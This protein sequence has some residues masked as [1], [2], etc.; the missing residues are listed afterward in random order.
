MRRRLVLVFFAISTLVA[1]AFVIPLGVL[2]G[3]T[4][5][6]RAID[7][8]RADA[9]AVV[10]A[11]TAS[12]SRAQ[13]ESAMGATAAGSDGRMSVITSQGWVIGAEASQSTLIETALEF[14]SS[15]IGPVDGGVEVVAAVAS[16][17]SE[18]SAI[19]VFVPQESLESGRWRAWSVLAAVGLA[20]VGI[21]V[22]VADRLARTVTV[23]MTQLVNAA[24]SL[25]EGDL[26]V[27]VSPDGP[28]ELADLAGAFNDLGTRVSTMLDRER[29]LVADLSHRMRTPL[30]KLRL[31]VDQVDDPTLAQELRSDLDD[32]TKEVNELIL[33]ARGAIASRPGCDLNDVAT[34]RAEFWRVL[35]DDQERPWIFKAAGRPLF[36]EPPVGDVAAA[37]DVLI[38]NVFSHTPEGAALS[39]SCGRRDDVAE[40]VVGDGGAGFASEAA[41]RGASS[42]GSTGLGLDIARQTAM[43]FGGSLDIGV[44][45]LGG[46]SV[47]LRLPVIAPRT[48]N[49]DH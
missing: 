41:R 1:T 5:E 40:F 20:L 44:S 11:L 26:E 23:P 43:A 39:I 24:R 3:R 32:V 34:D 47:S 10:P 2:V 25:G 29:E 28:D 4:A 17:P 19:R 33:E 14:G 46:A 48:V 6:D 35:A 31:R 8:A 18:T 7:A 27:T 15:D 22:F 21:S 42:A 45:D 49:G 9:S 13:I 36:V 38:E 30:T 37:I 12:A 16:G